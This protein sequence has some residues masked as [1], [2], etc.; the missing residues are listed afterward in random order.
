MQIND[1]DTIVKLLKRRKPS[2][3]GSAVFLILAAIYFTYSIFTD[4]SITEKTGFGQ[5][6]KTSEPL[7]LSNLILY[8]G[9]YVIL[10]IAWTSLFVY[11]NYLLG[12]AM[13]IYLGKSVRDSSF[14]ERKNA[15]KALF[16]GM[17]YGFSD[18]SFRQSPLS[19]TE[20]NPD[21]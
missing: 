20:Q 6:I 3:I 7:I 8:F 13:K 16:H 14:N 4:V 19:L 21:P 2:I 5:T 11:G 18:E 17:K 12:K 15:R 9:I 1:K 10:L